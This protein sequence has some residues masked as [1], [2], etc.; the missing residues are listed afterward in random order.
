M[1]MMKENSEKYVPNLSEFHKHRLHRSEG[2]GKIMLIC[3][4]HVQ[5]A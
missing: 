1:K 5:Q 2:F 3:K 4:I